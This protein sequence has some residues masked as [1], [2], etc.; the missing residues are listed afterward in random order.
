MNRTGQLA[1]LSGRTAGPIAASCLAL[2]LSLAMGAC[3]GNLNKTP[4]ATYTLTVNSTN[5]ASCVTIGVTYP[6][7]SLATQNAQLY[8]ERR[9]WVNVWTQRARNR[10]GQSILVVEQRMHIRRQPDV[11]CHAQQ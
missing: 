5:P 7:T 6:P 10:G 2:A 11:Q 3:S 9:G 4:P 1:V 8:L